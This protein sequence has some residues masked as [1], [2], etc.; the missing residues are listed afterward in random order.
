MN[1]KEFIAMAK[2]I[3]ESPDRLAHYRKI[4]K[5]VYLFS[6]GMFKILL[7]NE[8]KPE[9]TV[10]FLNAMLGLDGDKAISNFTFG[11]QENPGA[12]NEKT[13]FFDIYGTTQAGEPVL[14]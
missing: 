3:K 11:L 13:A 9:R 8:A 6:D 14:I 1:R 7:A 12:L 4:F 10:M 2:D 5:N